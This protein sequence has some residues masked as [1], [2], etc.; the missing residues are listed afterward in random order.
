MKNIFN[1]R[2]YSTQIKTGR[3]YLGD[4]VAGLRNFYESSRTLDYLRSR[5][6]SPRSMPPAAR[7]RFYDNKDEIIEFNDIL[8]DVIKTDA[9]QFDFEQLL[10]F[11]TTKFSSTTHSHQH[12]ADFR[13]RAREAIIGMRNEMAVEQLLTAGGIEFRRGTVLEDSKGGDYIIDG[14][15]FDFKSDEYSTQRA[16][17]RAEEG[18]YDSSTILWS[19]VH[20][21]DFEGKLVLPYDKC[22]AIIAELKPELEAAI[23]ANKR[24]Q[25]VHA[26]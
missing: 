16:R 2:Q 26:I 7:N 9:P 14:V 8:V 5:Y 17:M 22:Q 4:M 25:T 18:G 11:M 13:A 21:E 19:H 20:F 12:I 1:P 3:Q 23:A 24:P 15:P 6:G 10:D